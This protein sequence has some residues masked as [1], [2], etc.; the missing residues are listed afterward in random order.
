MAEPIP[1]SGKGIEKC[2]WKI[3]LEYALG[4]KE[5]TTFR[6]IIKYQIYTPCAKCLGYDKKCI[7]YA[8]QNKQ[9]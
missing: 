2:I 1:P 7:K 8:G 3:S 9:T 4:F 6:D 5:G